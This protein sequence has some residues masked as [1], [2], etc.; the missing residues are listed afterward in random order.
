[1]DSINMYDLVTLSDAYQRALCFGKQNR[2]VGDSSSTAITAGSSGSGNVASHLFP[3][4]QD[5]LEYKK[6]EKRTLFV[7]PTE[8]EDD[9]VADDDYE[10][11]SVFDDDQYEEEILSGDVGVNLMVRRSCLTPQAIGDDWLKHSIF[12]STCTILVPMDAYHLLLGRTWEYDRNKT[13]DQRANTYSFMF[14]SV[15]ITLMPNK[16]KELVNKPTGTL[17]TLSYLEDELEMGDEV[18]KVVH[19]NLIRS[20]TI[21]K[22]MQI[23]SNDMWILKWVTFYG[24]FNYGPFPDW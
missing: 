8:W 21:Y 6:A 18:H 24:L 17:L 10:E 12:Q 16:H 5:R 14:G 22:Q 2:W 15:K 13:H 4:K 19:D 9:G 11:P 23:K 20:N 7:E 1:M 3:I